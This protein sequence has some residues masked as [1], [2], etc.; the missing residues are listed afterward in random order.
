M[1]ILTILN[2]TKQNKN[3]HYLWV[4]GNGEDVYIAFTCVQLLLLQLFPIPVTCVAATHM[5][6]HH[7]HTE[8]LL[9]NL[10][11][12]HLGL[13]QEALC[14]FMILL[15]LHKNKNSMACS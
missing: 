3:L 12:L 11:A 2:K 8:I 10:C 5:V 6:H 15:C 4:G 7:D 13:Q 14:F 9:Q 1:A